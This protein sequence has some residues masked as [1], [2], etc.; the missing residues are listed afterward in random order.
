L[1]GESQDKALVEAVN[2]GDAVGTADLV[3]RIMAGDQQAE[4]LL[5]QRYSRG[6]SIIIRRAANNA[7]VAEDLRQETFRIALEK[8]RHGDVREPE[9][10]SS[11][12][13]GLARNLVIGHFRRASRQESLSEIE[14]TRPF[15]HS[16]PSQFDLLLQ[17]EK[18]NDCAKG[19]R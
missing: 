3:K 12:I 1:D 18:A 11:F 14:E 2:L 6:I 10:L 5:I 17:K 7:D 16:G 4:E 19:S 15:S 9:K 13:C 8:I